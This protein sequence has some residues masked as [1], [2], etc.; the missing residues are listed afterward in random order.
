[1]SEK[2]NR[3]KGNSPDQKLEAVIFEKGRNSILIRL[4]DL[5]NIGGLSL[6]RYSEEN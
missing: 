4:V 6:H 5:E 1:M 2:V 3:Q